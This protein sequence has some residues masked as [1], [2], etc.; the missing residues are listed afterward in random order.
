MASE[1]YWRNRC[2]SEQEAVRRLYEAQELVR[3]ND[4]CPTPPPE[5]ERFDLW[6]MYDE[7]LCVAVITMFDGVEPPITYGPIL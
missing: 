4:D 7:Q 3:I 1:S 2:V 6:D 5:Y